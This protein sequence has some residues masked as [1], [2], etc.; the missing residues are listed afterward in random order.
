MRDEFLEPVK[1]ILAAR[2]GHVCSNPSCRRATSGPQANPSGVINIGVAAHITAA[3]PLG[4]RYD[5][6]ATAEQRCASEN[7]IWLCQTCA[8]LVDNDPIRFT[9]DVLRSWKGQAEMLA[10]HDLENRVPYLSIENSQEILENYSKLRDGSLEIMQ[11]AAHY[12]GIAALALNEWAQLERVPEC[13]PHLR[14]FYNNA[15]RQF[16]S[17]MSAL[18]ASDRRAKAKS[19]PKLRKWAELLR[20]RDEIDASALE[21]MERK[22]K[23]SAG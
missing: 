9:A 21:L 10:V 14:D 13:V 7:G 17:F 11:S 19:L 5:E 4:P 3:S 1:R 16:V 18:E 15:I 6:T 2:A 20:V 22:R 8:K 23:R 12:A